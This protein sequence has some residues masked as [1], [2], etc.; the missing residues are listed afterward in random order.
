MTTD[1]EPRT[2]PTPV[3][4]R[5]RATAALVA[6]ALTSFVLVGAEFMPGGLLTAIAAD[7]GVTVGQAGQTVTITALA[8]LFTAP[9]IGM[10]APRLDRRTLMVVLALAAALSDLA[11]A[12]SPN[13]VIMLVSR[14]L[15]GAAIGAFWAMSLAVVSFITRGGDVARGMMIVNIGNTLATVVGVP[16]GIALSALVSWREVFVGAALI[17]VLTAVVLRLTLPSVPP[18]G[19][20]TLRSLA[21]VLRRPGI[22]HALFG[23]VLVV[24][25]HMAGYAFIRVL[26]ERIPGTDGA[27]I[28]VALTAFGVG[29]FLGNLLVGMIAARTLRS[30]SIIV[31]AVLGASLLGLAVWPALPF[32]IIAVTAWGASFGAWL[33]VINTWTAR[34]VPD[35]L[36]AGGSLVVVGFQ[37]A[38]VIGAALGGIVVDSYG[39]GTLGVIAGVVAVIGGALF[40]TARPSSRHRDGAVP[41]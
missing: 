18:A 7:M 23:H 6:M 37:L 31:P 3:P 13:L 22:G 38:I 5:R 26:V 19:A 15:I 24:L 28:A 29:G 17:T 27:G 40:A 12:L 8:G 2:H 10:L 33:V 30:L 39:A 16:I 35:E 11:V 4:Q 34:N 14:F 21:A 9:L 20:T 41:V 1:T 25:G 32:A 36:E